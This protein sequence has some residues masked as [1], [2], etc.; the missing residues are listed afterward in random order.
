MRA[1]NDLFGQRLLLAE[2]GGEALVV[3][4]VD[5]GVERDGRGARTRHS[6]FQKWPACLT[7]SIIQI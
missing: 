7:N 1:I 6:P 4:G 3:A 2:A 5:R